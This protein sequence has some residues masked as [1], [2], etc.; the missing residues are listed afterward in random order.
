MNFKGVFSLSF[1]SQLPQMY[2]GPVLF[3]WIL[4][5]SKVL[6]IQLDTMILLFVAC[7]L[8][9]YQQ[10]QA[11]QEDTLEGFFE[12]ALNNG[13]N[14]WQY[15]IA[16]IFAHT[17][18]SI[19]PLTFIIYLN[20]K[21]FSSCLLVG[22]QLLVINYLTCAFACVDKKL[23]SN[24]LLLIGL[25]LITAPTIFL[26][27]LLCDFNKSSIYLFIGCNVMLVTLVSMILFSNSKKLDSFQF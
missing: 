26:Y 10:F 1:L 4:I 6:A 25:P 2:V 23:V 20:N 11:I 27:S 5:V 14:L 17:I 22:T 3:A 15:V 21:K 8:V 24:Q 12:Y 9:V 7:I 13:T 19:L 16:K 18:T